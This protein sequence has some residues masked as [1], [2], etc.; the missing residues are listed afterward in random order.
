M[1]GIRT[2]DEGL[3]FSKEQL[4]NL[5]DE[6]PTPFHIYDER[7]IRTTVKN[8]IS[9]FSW[10][11]GFKEYYAVKANPNP[12]LLRLLHGEGCG[13]DCS[14]FCELALADKLGIRGEEIMFSSNDTPANEFRYAKELGALI[15]LDDIG[16]IAFLKREAG[17]PSL[18]SLRYNPGLEKEGN[19]I[20]GD[21]TEAKYG[22]TREQVFE[23]YS[24]LKSEGVR[25]FGLHAMVASN[26]LNPQ[27]FVET[28]EILFALAA[29][30]E[31]KLGISLDFINL[32]GG[33]GIPYRPQDEAVDLSIVSR[34][35]ER[36]YR[37]I[38]VEKGLSAPKVFFECGRVITGP[39][40]FL[41]S[42][43]LHVKKTYK[44]F[45]G[46]DACMAHLMR[47]AIYGAYHH[48]TALGKEATADR[49]CCDVTGSLCENN[50]KFAIDRELPALEPGDLCVIHDTG[51]HG[52][53]MGFNYNGKLR[54]AEFLYREDSSFEMIRREE[55]LQDYFATMIF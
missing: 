23:G 44:T 27:Y 33:I 26:E 43:V 5:A 30:I 37:E 40:G 34:G 54:C 10:A 49:I 21:P 42:R 11:D 16:H 7:G 6:H 51:A 17:L 15:N 24:L 38:L 3:P 31:S 22:F 45:V 19:S 20:I 13:M 4:E 52:Y 55:K 12:S 39:H 48:I 29:E 9:A 36:A 18:V 2:K 50:D 8:F 53:S 46:L 14:S 35:I 28:A 41:V 25:S 32:G 1:Q 47:P